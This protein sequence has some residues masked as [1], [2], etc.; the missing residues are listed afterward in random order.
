MAPDEI[1]GSTSK[2]KIYMY[3]IHIEVSGITSRLYHILS[4]YLSSCVDDIFL[5]KICTPV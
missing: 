1:A 4:A 3:T 2:K 5:S